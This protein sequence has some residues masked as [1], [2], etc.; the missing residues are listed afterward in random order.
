M[1]TQDFVDKMSVSFREL[2]PF[3][4]CEINDFIRTTESR[5]KKAAQ[6]LWNKLEE[7]NQIYLSKYSGW[8]SVSD[9]AFYNEDEVEEKAGSK[10]AKLS[11]SIVEWVEEESYFF[12]LSEWEKPLLEFYEK[13]KNLI[14]KKDFFK[15]ISIKSVWSMTVDE[16]LNLSGIKNIDY[17]N[18][19]VEGMDFKI[20]HQLIPNK[21]KPELNSIETHK[22]DGSKSQDCDKINDH[23]KDN[24]FKTFKRVGPTTLFSG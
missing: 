22:V 4:G 23:L 20:L 18:I 15:T 7:N 12:K 14:F 17:I 24:N 16:I 3:L 5:H 1:D 11:G 9:E 19:D 6:A 8:Y 13:N 21:M 10:V 2:I